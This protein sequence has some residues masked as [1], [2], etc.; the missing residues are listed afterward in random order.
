MEKISQH[1]YDETALEAH[2]AKAPDV[3]ESFECG[4]ENDEV[5]PNIWLPEGVL[6]GFKEACLEFF[7]VFPPVTCSIYLCLSI[8][9]Q[10]L[11]RAPKIRP[12]SNR[13]RTFSSGGLLLA[14]P[15]CP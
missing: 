10:G 1:I 4:R 3:K 14:F 6:P 9:K 5:M 12:Q 15:H 8:A 2:R 7:W 13:S 11:L